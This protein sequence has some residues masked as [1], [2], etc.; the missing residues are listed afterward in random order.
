[1]VL[2]KDYCQRNLCFTK[3]FLIFLITF[4][5]LADLIASDLSVSAYV[6]QNKI[7]LD[8][9]FQLNIEVSGSEFSH[10]EQPLLPNIP[11]D[12]LGM[13]QSS[14]TSVSIINGKMTSVKKK[15][16]TYSLQPKRKGNFNIPSILVKIDGKVFKTNGISLSVTEYNK[17]QQAQ[18]SWSSD[19][20]FKTSGQIKDDDIIFVAEPSKT[21][22]Y[23]N[24]SF[25]VDYTLY[26]QYN[27]QLNR[28]GDEP[29]FNGFWKEDISGDNNIKMIETTFRGKKYYAFHI[30]KLILSPNKK[31]TLQ[32][33][34]L[35][36]LTD[37][38]VP[39]GNFFGFSQT[40]ALSVKSRPVNINVIDL[41][42]IP[43]GVNF[44]GAVGQFNL[45]SKL[46]PQTLKAG[47]TATLT[48]TITGKGNLSQ[49]NNPEFPPVTNLKVLGPEVENK[50]VNNDQSLN[51]TRIVKYAFLP[52]D[53][54][55]YS[56]SPA[57]F[58]FFDPAQRKYITQKIPTYKI[59]AERGNI[60]LTTSNSQNVISSE[61]SDIGFIVTDLAFIEFPV[62]FK[63]GFFWIIVFLLF[64]SIPA[65]YFYK[66]EQDKL[67]SNL[68]Y[69]RHR[70][71]SKILKKYLKDASFAY[72]HQQDNQFYDY[73]Y[74]GILQYLTDK[75][76]I[77]RG[78]TK[79][80]IF[81]TLLHHLDN[82]TLYRELDAFM[83]K[84]TQFKFMPGT[85]GHNDLNK[86]YQQLKY[87]VDEL[88]KN[89]K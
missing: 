50:T 23:R 13:S 78:S 29:S 18:N 79:A 77:S 52:Q 64:L 28:L 20:Q 75:L 70:K 16:F 54:G 14:S 26:T 84:C 49:M 27:L 53:E 63:S 45:E 33:P 21:T 43:R 56:T 88:T 15:T 68:D 39:S 76:A 5:V 46:S 59:Q 38:V 8:E 19:P 69:L 57:E 80:E 89:I 67:S 74:K 71:A 37:V 12:N 85:E 61:G 30:R 87:I 32:I 36:I 11:F 51:V 47:E 60:V 9:V 35:S 42:E 2:K 55:L 73:S 31:G 24:E 44:S 82:E 3:L 4:G 66:L 34:S 65:H 6:D 1:M 58:N 62:L 86:D 7:S 48:L 41:P 17:Q 81:E 72:K 40:R 83:D 22:L 10:I 25:I